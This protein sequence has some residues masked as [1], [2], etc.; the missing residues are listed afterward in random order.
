MLIA[1]CSHAAGSEMDG[2]EDSRSNRLN[3]FGGLLAYK[4]QRRPINIAVMASSNLSIA[5]SVIQWFD[6]VY[7]SATME[8][9]VLIA[10]TESSRMEIPSCV[11]QEY[12]SGNPAIDWLPSECEK[13]LRVNFSSMSTDEISQEQISQAQ[14]FM[15]SNSPFLEINSAMQAMHVRSFLENLSVKYCMC[16]TG[17]MFSDADYMKFYLKQLDPSCYLNIGKDISTTFYSKY[18]DA[19]YIH[20]RA[21]Y[22]HHGPVPHKLYAD[23]LYKFITES[24]VTK[25][26][27][28]QTGAI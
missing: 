26:N 17:Y 18:K 9:F 16:D 7:D 1:G 4:M 11:R 25:P 14:R 10:W 21:K 19:G 23:E 15:V 12:Y 22:F 6:E 8:V 27:H 20:P 28:P 13:Y 2:T 5:R 3:S 24:R